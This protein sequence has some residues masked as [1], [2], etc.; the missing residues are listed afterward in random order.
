MSEKVDPY[1]DRISKLPAP[2]TFGVIW[3][4]FQYPM[5]NLG[6]IVDFERKGPLLNVF[7]PQSAKVCP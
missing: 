1:Y 7:R 5:G 4:A 6:Q 2:S 3:P